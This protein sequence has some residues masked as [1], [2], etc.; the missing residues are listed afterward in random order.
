MYAGRQVTR[1]VIERAG[2]GL[3]AFYDVA[4]PMHA[5]GSGQL[6]RPSTRIVFSIAGLGAAA[7]A[8]LVR[9]AKPRASLGDGALGLL[10]LCLGVG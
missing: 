4:L 10:L 8:P 3:V 6:E 9:F 5:S 1:Y 7:W 2:G